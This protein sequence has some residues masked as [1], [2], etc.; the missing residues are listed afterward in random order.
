[1][2]VVAFRAR[3]D[4]EHRMRMTQYRA[5]TT[6][7]SREKHAKMYATRWSELARL[8]YFDMCKMIAIDPMHNLLLGKQPTGDSLSHTT[9]TH[10]ML[11]LV[12]THFYHIWVQLRV[13]RKTKELRRFQEILRTVCYPRRLFVMHGLMSM[14][15]ISLPSSLGRLPR[16]I[17]ESGG[18]SLTADQWLILAT[19]VG[20]LA[21]SSAFPSCSV[22]W[23]TATGAI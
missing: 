14:V 23:L 12:K 1:M 18:G 3:T 6:P 11:G 10:P 22:H 9:L 20:P 21:V 16:L 13:F 5:C 4:V 15:Q 8:P 2:K 17:D 7:A 19:K